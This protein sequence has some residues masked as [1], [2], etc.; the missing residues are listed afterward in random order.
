VVSE[1][2]AREFEQRFRTVIDLAADT[3]EAIVILQTIDGIEG[4]YIYVNDLWSDITGY[5]KE[6]LLTMSAFDLIAPEHVEASRDR[7]NKVLAGEAQ[8]KLFEVAIITKSRKV[9]PVELSIAPIKYNGASSVVAHLRDIS[10]KKWAEKVIMEERLKYFSLFENAPVP[11][12]EHD[13]SA[14]CLII[15]DMQE[16][17][18]K[19]VKEYAETHHDKII[20]CLRNSHLIAWNKA[21]RDF[22]EIKN[23][24]V[25]DEI[26][27]NASAND[28]NSSIS[29]SLLS[30]LYGLI[31]GSK[32]FSHEDVINTYHGKRKNI[33][34]NVLVA[35]G[36]ADSLERVYISFYEITTLKTTENKLKE[37]QNRLEQMVEERT[38]QLNELRQKEVLLLHKERESSQKLK[39]EL[40]KRITPVEIIPGK[41]SGQLKKRVLRFLAQPEIKKLYHRLE[42]DDKNFGRIFVHFKH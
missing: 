41:G 15:Q 25:A 14:A 31:D 1:A 40:E 12:A 34:V 42:K 11:I 13:F 7:Y 18:I 33:I 22:F 5:S 35:P 36:S 24:E 37:Y 2:K 8:P 10:E 19:T 30:I 28:I 9:V 39:K 4:R 21:M 38:A 6:E 29:A 23:M 27:V 32:Q 16:K 26:I 17:N 3:G 20:E